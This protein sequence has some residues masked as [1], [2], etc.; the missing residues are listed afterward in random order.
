MFLKEINP[1]STEKWD[2]TQIK[3][4]LGVGIV[5]NA[6]FSVLDTNMLVSP[7]QNCG[8]GESKPT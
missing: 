4:A 8:V 1:Y 3:I 6:N 2:Q 5:G 7:T